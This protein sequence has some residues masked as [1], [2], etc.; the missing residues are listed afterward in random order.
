[1]AADVGISCVTVFGGSGFLGSEIARRLAAEGIAT[2]VADRHPDRVHQIR[3]PEPSDGIQRLYADV[4]DETSVALA[5]DGSDAVVN[6][7]GLYVEN[8]G[9]TFEAVH[10]IGALNVAHQCASLNVAR[11]VHLSGIGA[12]MFAKSRYV[13][14]RAKGELLVRDICAGAIILRPSIVV[15]PADAFLNALVKMARRSP[16]VPLFARGQM[17]LQPVYVGDVAEAAFNAIVRP[18]V[19]GKVYE[20]GG[21]RIYSYRDLMEMALEQARL[22]R[23]LLPVPFALWELLALSLSVLASPPL[24]RDQVTLMRRDNVVA[25]TALSLADLGVRPTALEDVLPMYAF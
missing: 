5:V 7:V 21:P 13:R 15:G 6:A 2:R 19:E 25:E 11:I 1:M 17:R 22:R 16:I 24:T 14:A 12:D 10:E 23:L 18:G 9:E 8:R 20:L 4:R 3:G